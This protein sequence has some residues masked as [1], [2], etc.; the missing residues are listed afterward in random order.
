[1]LP[2]PLQLEPAN[3]H[4][5]IGFRLRYMLD[6]GDYVYGEWSPTYD[7]QINYYDID[8]P[9]VNNLPLSVSGPS[10]TWYMD[11]ID[12]IGRPQYLTRAPDQWPDIY[13]TPLLGDNKTCSL[14][15]AGFIRVDVTIGTAS[16]DLN[17]TTFS[18]VIDN[19]TARATTY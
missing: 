1:M 6:S 5:T 13:W 9:I 2:P 16:I 18:T 3:V 19:I 10:S 4:M 8:F 7:V 12:L 11:N 14:T 15:Q 17:G